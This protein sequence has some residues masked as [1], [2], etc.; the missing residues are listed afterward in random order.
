MVTRSPAFSRSAARLM[1]SSS[2]MT[3]ERVGRISTV[4]STTDSASA[5][6]PG[7]TSTATPCFS[8]AVRIAISST[9]GIWL[10][11]ATYSV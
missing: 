2:G 8:T 11:W 6:S 3:R 1:A 5:T 7:I 4:R 9:C 10:G